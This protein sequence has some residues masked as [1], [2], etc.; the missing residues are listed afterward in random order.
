[1]ALFSRFFGRTVG[2]GAG[3]A[4]GTATANVVE[5]ALQELAN[6]AQEQ[7]PHRPLDP[8]DAAEL[9][10]REATGDIAG[11]DLGGVDPSREALYNGLR[12]A[13]FDALTE[14]A[15]EHPSVGE[16]LEL[17]RRNLAQGAGHGITREQF[18]EWMRRTGFTA[19]VVDALTGLETAYLA[20]A[21]I[22]NAVQQGFV[23]G[24]GIL[25]GDSGGT[26]ALTPPTEQV[27]IDPTNEAAVAGIDPDRLKV[28]AELSGNPPGPM[29]LLELWRRGDITETAVERGIREGRIKT[30]WTG[31]LKRLRW[32]LIPTAALVNL[33]LRGWIEDA[34]Y[35]DRMTLHGFHPETAD[36][37][38]HAIGRPATTHQ[39]VVGIRRGGVYGAP[40]SD[41][42]QPFRD[43]IIRSD[44]RP[45]WANILYHG[46]ETYPSAFVVRQLVQSGALTAAEGA[47]TLYKAGWPRELAD[48]AAAGFARGT[49]TTSKGLTQADLTAEYEG[50]FLTR[51]SFVAGLRELGYSDT[52]AAAKADSVDAK[53]VRTSRN[54][55][56]SRIHSQYTAHKVSRSAALDALQQAAVPA[57]VRDLLMPDWDLERELTADALTAAQIKKAWK[58][59][60]MARAEAISRLEWKGYEEADAG[61]Y[62]DQ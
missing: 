11:I 53:R 33:R 28:L 27:P 21:D 13:R 58:N 2:E 45:E 10:A 19:E 48:Q 40:L 31:A 38:F 41:T 7:Y 52:D 4:I 20:P 61:I 43:A 18:R 15:R 25:P 23:P 54:R 14:L 49:G 55:L 46:R 60:Q 5:P 39:I 8:R 29:E 6:A 50:L 59:G 44:I 30:K 62:L 9:R 36:D 12:Q 37:M 1:M 51:A 57:R 42:P 34:E 35:H 3:V 47:D 22:A 17:R 16:L 32:Q 26:G 56:I 24:A